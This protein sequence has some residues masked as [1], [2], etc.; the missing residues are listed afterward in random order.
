M[1]D[2]WDRRY[3]VPGRPVNSMLEERAY[4]D[5]DGIRHPDGRQKTMHSI[6]RA[7]AGAGRGD[8][9]SNSIY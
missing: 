9:V 5:D 1:L 2:M 7:T 6:P 3:G 8:C 4:R